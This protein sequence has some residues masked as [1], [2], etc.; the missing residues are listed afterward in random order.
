MLCSLAPE[1]IYMISDRLTLPC[2]A[3]ITQTCHSFHNILTPEF[4]KRAVEDDKG[5]RGLYHAAATDNCALARHLLYYGADPNVSCDEN[6]RTPLHIA[7]EFGH[8]SIVRLLLQHGADML[9]SSW[10]L[11][12][13]ERLYPVYG[14]LSALGS[15]VMNGHADVVE[16][17][18]GEM[19]RNGISKDTFSGETLFQMAAAE[20]HTDVVRLFLKSGMDPVALSWL[21]RDPI[22]RGYAEIVEMMIEAGADVEARPSTWRPLHSVAHKGH[23]DVARVL[24]EHGAEVDALSHSSHDQ[25][26]TPLVTAVKMGALGPSERALISQHSEED[27]LMEF[28][29]CKTGALEV[30]KVLIEWGADVDW[31]IHLAHGL[32]LA[33]EHRQEIVELLEDVRK[34]VVVRS[35]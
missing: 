10:D 26:K 21:M 19:D 18:L 35:G 11:A 29:R 3:S 7:A 23:V 1:L 31:A 8:L 2:L 20:R 14:P 16:L 12:F 28:Q 24:L 27:R 13:E 34:D 32:D 4:Y 15:A 5:L 6:Q 17:L 30:A 9:L 22:Q 25:P 33:A